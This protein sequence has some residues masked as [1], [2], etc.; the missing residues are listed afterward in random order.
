MVERL[1]ILGP[2]A[3]FRLA[4][5]PESPQLNWGVS[6]Q[7]TPE[8]GM[9]P[10]YQASSWSVELPNSWSVDPQSDHVAVWSPGGAELR[11]TTFLP[12]EAGLSAARWVETAVHFNR[13]R[14]RPVEPAACGDFKGYETWFSTDGLRIHGWVLAAGEMPLD[15][16]YRGS[17]SQAD[18]EIA[19]VRRTLATLRRTA[20]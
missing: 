3:H 4:R 15:M 1:A 12:T 16:T 13:I 8:A 10:V 6:Q 14:G 9:V 11:F 17:A 20:G 5:R 19:V 7:Q 2:G 18:P